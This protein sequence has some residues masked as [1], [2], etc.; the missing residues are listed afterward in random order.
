M[1]IDALIAAAS[2]GNVEAAH[3][4]LTHAYKNY[5]DKPSILVW[6]KAVAGSLEHLGP[7]AKYAT[8]G[9]LINADERSLSYEILRDLAWDDGYPPAQWQLGR[10]IANEEIILDDAD[11][12]TGFDLL[13]TAQE[14][15]HLRARQSILMARAG[16]MVF[17]ISI[18]YR[19]VAYCLG[20]RTAILKVVFKKQ[21]ET[22]I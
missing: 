15:G 18:I 8:A 21:D 3:K 20:F 13:R 10:M 7:R 14:N 1:D 17:P 6:S 16:D 9:L 12:E 2:R 22:V 19:I 5:D 4:L 11:R